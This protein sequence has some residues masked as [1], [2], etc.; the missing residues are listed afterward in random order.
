MNFSTVPPE[1]L[2]LSAESGVI[3]LEHRA[4][5]F[6]S[7]CSARDVK[8]TRSQSTLTIFRSLDRRAAPASRAEP[9]RDRSGRVGILLPTV[10]H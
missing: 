7:S 8:P 9:Q 6:R 5:V 3:R 4:D 1:A 10:R 2:E